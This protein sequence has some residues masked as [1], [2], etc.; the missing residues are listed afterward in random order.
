M[1]RTLTLT[2]D[3]RGIQQVPAYLPSNYRVVSIEPDTYDPDRFMVMTIVGTD[4]CGWT[5]EYV[6]DRLASG[7]YFAREVE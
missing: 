5:A 6:M 2:T 4:S 1:E 7:L 3:E